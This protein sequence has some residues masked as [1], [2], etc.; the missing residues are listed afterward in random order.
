[1]RRA[2]RGTVD[3]QRESSGKRRTRRRT[4]YIGMDY[5]MNQVDLIR[6]NDFNAAKGFC[7]VGVR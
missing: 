6:P 3:R 4:I 7:N 5:P 1:M 2:G